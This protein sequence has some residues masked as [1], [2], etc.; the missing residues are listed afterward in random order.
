[1]QDIELKVGTQLPLDKVQGLYRSS[2]LGERRP[3]DDAECLAEMI[4][5]ASLIVTAW[6]GQEL[7]GISRTLTDRCYVA[8]LADLAVAKDHQRQG[9]GTALIERTR[10]ELGERCMI[11]LLSAPAAE[12]YYPRVGFKHHPQAWVLSADDPLKPATDRPS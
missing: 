12:A 1:M 9:I 10:Q 2:T 3:I 5:R 7:V 11:V 6:D 4:E 8:Y